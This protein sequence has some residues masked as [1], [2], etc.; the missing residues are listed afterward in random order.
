MAASIKKKFI[1]NLDESKDKLESDQDLDIKIKIEIINILI[2]MMDIRH[3]DCINQIINFIKNSVSELFPT[4]S[5]Y[6]EALIQKAIRMNLVSYLPG[7]FENGF[8][9]LNQNNNGI[10]FNHDFDRITEKPLLPLLLYI[11]QNTNDYDLNYLVLNLIFKMF[12]QRRRIIKSIK[13]V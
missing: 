11:F 6:N 1:R 13:K 12:E 10:Q 7:I 3:D 2:F 8:G 5:N 9:K 4:Q